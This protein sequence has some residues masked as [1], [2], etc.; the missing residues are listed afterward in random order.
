MIDLESLRTG[1]S[2]EFGIEVTH[3][4][5][6]KDWYD[7]LRDEDISENETDFLFDN[8]RVYNEPKC[9]VTDLHRYELC[10]NCHRTLERC[11]CPK[12]TPWY[13]LLATPEEIV[14]MKKE[15]PHDTDI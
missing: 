4:D 8:G 10:Q 13:G 11:E 5:G 2:R 7:P 3:K 6:N 12:T 9:N 14:M 1:D 15:K